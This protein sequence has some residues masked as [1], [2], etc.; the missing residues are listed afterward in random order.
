MSVFT[1]LFKDEEKTI[2]SEFN[3]LILYNR[4]YYLYTNEAIEP[5]A[6]PCYFQVENFT[7]IGNTWGSPLLNFCEWFSSKIQDDFDY[8]NYRL[9][10]GK[11]LF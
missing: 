11:H 10:D 3:V 8:I 2:L 4:R 6:V 9:K 7:Y 1:P 5:Y